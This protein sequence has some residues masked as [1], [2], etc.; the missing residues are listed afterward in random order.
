VGRL[1]PSKNYS[2]IPEQRT[3]KAQNNNKKKTAD[4]S[5]IGQI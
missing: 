1:E 2:K 4:Q 3:G 5:H